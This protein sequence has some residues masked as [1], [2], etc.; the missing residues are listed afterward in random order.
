MILIINLR[1]K[2]KIRIAEEKVRKREMDKESLKKKADKY[3]VRRKDP[4]IERL[5]EVAPRGK[6]TKVSD[7]R[8]K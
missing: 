6:I 1:F 5:R 4:F 2:R 7:H 8:R 3:P